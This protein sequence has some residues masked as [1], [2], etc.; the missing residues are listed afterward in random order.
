MFSMS[1]RRKPESC[2]NVNNDPGFRRDDMNIIHLQ[3]NY[4]E[5]WVQDSRMIRSGART[6]WTRPDCLPVMIS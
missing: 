2:D 6:L 5:G 4:E 1:F 3:K